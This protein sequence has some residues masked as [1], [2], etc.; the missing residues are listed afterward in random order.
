MHINDP[1]ELCGR[2][3]GR[4]LINMHRYRPPAT[5]SRRFVRK[6]NRFPVSVRLRGRTGPLRKPVIEKTPQP[7]HSREDCRSGAHDYRILYQCEFCGMFN[8]RCRVC[9][10]EKRCGCI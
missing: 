9:S 1:F 7:Q 3:E 2:C 6:L 8:Y 4:G 5:N 10:D